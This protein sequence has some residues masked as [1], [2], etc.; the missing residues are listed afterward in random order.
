MEARQPELR[1]FE[2]QD[3]WS[4]IQSCLYGLVE[5]D[6]SIIL[7]PDRVYIMGDGLVKIIDP[8]IISGNSWFTPDENIYYSPERFENFSNLNKINTT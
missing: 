8:D 2:E 4:I 1:Y 7:Q 6:Q 3:L 5:I